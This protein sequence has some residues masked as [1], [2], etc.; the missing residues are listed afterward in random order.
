MSERSGMISVIALILLV[1]MAGLSVSYVSFTNSSVLK[2]DNFVRGQSAQ[3]T[4][5]SGL[6][7]MLYRLR[8]A[9]LP[10]STTS[11]MMMMRLRAS[12]SEHLDFTPNLGNTYVDMADNDVLVP[13]IQSGSGS[14][15][16]RFTQIAE[17]RCRM[18]VTGTVGDVS[19]S[20]SIDLDMGPAAANT[21]GR[22]IA[23]RGRIDIWGH[24]LVLG[25]NRPEEAQMLS[26][27]PEEDAIELKGDVTIGGDLFLTDE[28]A[29]VNLHGGGGGDPSVGGETDADLILSEHV[30]LVDPPILPTVDTT[31]FE[32]LV[33][34][35]PDLPNYNSGTCTN[36]RIKAGTDPALGHCAVLNGVVYVE[37]PNKVT[38]KSNCILN[39]FVVTEDGS[40]KDP[41]DCQIIFKAGMRSTPVE[42]LPDVIDGIS[43]LE[44]KQHTG[45]F[46][47]APGF[48]VDFYGHANTI[49]GAVAADKI[50]FW[51]HAE[52]EVTG[53]IL[54][55]TDEVMTLHGHSKITIDSDGAD[56]NP[57]GFVLPKVLVPNY[58]SY[59]EPTGGS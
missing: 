10:G 49:T 30:H 40:E 15:S 13:A 12:L 35:L 4:A 17:N 25:A 56:T 7:F 31:I 8:T 53:F 34:D 45:T 58:D 50:D 28:D 46:V 42:D 22:G 5:E 55:L 14:F 44:V 57:A 39:G 18:T 19:R 21:W 41:R 59:R 3:L 32:A 23:S 52:I 54:G 2:A 26:L 16:S 9:T 11:D 29:T 27:L 6:A 47:L 33:T 1:A 37:A 43:M 36:V 20:V 24:S 38:F 51:G 48:G